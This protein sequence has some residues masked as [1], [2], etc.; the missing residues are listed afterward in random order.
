MLTWKGKEV[1]DKTMLAAGRA[2]NGCTADIVTDAKSSS[3]VKTSAYQGSIQS[4][5]AYQAADNTIMAQLGSFAI[6][7]AMIIEFGSRA[8]VILP[9]VKKALS[10]PGAA[11]PVRMVFHPGTA[12]RHTLMN[13]FNRHTPS[14]PLR[15]KM[16]LGE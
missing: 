9:N 16:E 14:L 3:P 10:W 15:I 7:Y 8:H 5:P 13:A 11:H 6:N 12:A 2:V 4:R 1:L